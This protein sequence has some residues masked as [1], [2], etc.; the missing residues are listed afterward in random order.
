MTLAQLISRLKDIEFELADHG[1]TSD[2]VQVLAENPNH[3]LLMELAAVSFTGW[4][5]IVLE[6]K[7]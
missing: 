3:Y 1:T 7:Q 5:R 2:Q 4:P 6:F